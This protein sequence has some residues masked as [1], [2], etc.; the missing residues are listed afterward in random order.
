MREEATS[1]DL[2][3]QASGPRLTGFLT[4]ASRD[5]SLVCSAP[6]GTKYAVFV[7]CFS[8]PLFV[9]GLRNKGE[10]EPRA[11]PGPAASPCHPPARS[12]L[13]GHA[14][15]DAGGKH[16]TRTRV[17]MATRTLRA[18]CAPRTHTCAAGR[19]CTP[20]PRWEPFAEEA[21]NESEAPRG[22]LPEPDPQQRGDASQ[23]VFCRRTESAWFSRTLNPSEAAPG[24]PAPAR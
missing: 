8:E 18:L 20:A 1:D 7:L 13:S 11:S 19:V 6:G 2:I 12:L 5:N 24:L 3:P 17:H 22:P 10:M 9:W 14:D 4:T 15:P 21:A 16:D 23:N